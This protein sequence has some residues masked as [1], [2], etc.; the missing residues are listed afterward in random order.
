MCN[1]IECNQI[2]TSSERVE[3]VRLRKKEE[4]DQD[5]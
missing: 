3:E 4:N 5:D 1:L 2:Y